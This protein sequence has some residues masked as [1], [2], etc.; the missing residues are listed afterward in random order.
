MATQV[1]SDEE[2]DKLRGFP[3]IGRDELFR[4]F[5]PT[6]ADVAFVDPGRG[7]GPA[8]R[9]GLAVALC[10]LPWLGF[11]PDK[12]SSAP[13]VAV[14]R[15]ADQLGVDPDELRSYGRRTKTR[16]EHLRLVA[17]YRG[18][19]LPATMELKELDEFLLARALE[20]DSPTLLFRLACE[21]LI[22][23]RV[24]RPGP[25]TV[26]ERVAHARAEAQRET[27]DRLAREFTEARCAGLDALLVTDPGIGMT[28]LRWLS[29]GPVEA[30]PAAVKA[31]V[32]KL[33]FLRGLGAD[34]LDLSVL[35]AERRRF[36][37]TVGR[38]LTAQALERRDP[39]RRYPILLTMLAQSATDVL[40]EVVQLFDQA[41]SARESKAERK[42]RDALAERGRT[43]EDRQALLDDL[44]AIITDP[45]V[46]DEQIGGLIRGDRI[47]WP[48]LRSAMAQAV[49]RLPRDHGHL[50]ALDGSYG[51]LRQF[52]P[53]VLAAV[54]FAGGTAAAGLLDA[55]EILRGLNA[56]GARRVPADA[57][58]GFVPARWRGY[59]ET[60]AT[61]GNTSDY[62]HYWELCTL[63]ALRD[64]L[65]TGDVFVPGSRRYSDPA[66]YLLTPEKW[67]LQRA[68]FCQLVGKPADPA[69]ALAD[70][71]DEL[72]EALGELEVVLA[73]GDG[74]VRLDEDGDLVI[75]P[76]S[77]EDI[78]VEATALKAELT[79]MLP[80]APIVSLLIELDKR[81]GYLDCFT[82][83]GGKQARSPEL[84]RNLIAVLISHST[85]L[86]L[87]RMADACGISYDVLAWTAEWYVREETLRAANLALIDYHQRLPLA[88]VFGTGTLS[89][90]DG[91]RFPTRGKS[92]TAR[93]LSRYFANEGLSTYTHVTDQHT[94]YGTKVIVATK[95]EAH[96]VLDEILG[97][98]T[99]IPITEHATDTHGVTLVNFALFDL[100]GLQ[101]SPRIRDLGKITLTRM[102]SRAQVEADYPNAG[103][104]LTRKL[105]TE[106]IAEHYDDLLRVAGSLKFGHATA[107]L[108]VGKLSA[109]GRQNALAAA[110]KEYGALRRT[111]YAARYPAD[112]AYRRKISR[113]LNKGESL[114]ALKRDLLYAHEGAV[115]ARHLE[116]QTEQAWCLTLV[117]NAVVAWT[118]EYY[119]LA[120]DS[121]R[122]AGRRID[123]EV[124]AHISPAHSE[125]INFF[126]SIDVDV[127]GELAQLGPTGYRPLRV[128]DTLF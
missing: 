74:P 127:D 56:T 90:S 24:L 78:P 1:F 47:G 98:A 124:L 123:D 70:A 76:L 117:T 34:T 103:S 41:I 100:L 14:A 5:T 52:T 2:L 66:A 6:P 58:T 91:Q 36:L 48:R 113:Q 82:H 55:V 29:T 54:T 94:T 85:N 11:V 4:F 60:A 46:P 20:H 89:S 61:S 99:D 84:K 67:G 8:D 83:A 96:Y 104:L 45:A 22:S 112:P 13:P 105:N 120:V 64:G 30:S 38:R 111:I 88:P 31:E 115:R 75:S 12:V 35:P 93:A 3:E 59:L 81:T 121:M 118:T 119:G 63:L 28:R 80:F 92:V 10:T 126:G 73:A 33:E 37:A 50:T 27:F 68:E 102:G 51:Y 43:G 25:V 97:N 44:L 122:T 125:N 77:A 62:R 87:T 18:W 7:R 72:S 65:R 9:L 101:L 95:R 17:K 32:A 23:T 107:S 71:E 109:S 19:R 16:T 128:R 49:P 108:L 106:L 21:Y 69:H 110:L 26:V 15:L 116:Q 79:E 114:H 39:Q 86:G 53:H 40:D 42:M 57:P